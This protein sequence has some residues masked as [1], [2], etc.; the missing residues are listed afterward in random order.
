MSD[1]QRGMKV[2]FT[3]DWMRYKKGDEV[4]VSEAPGSNKVLTVVPHMGSGD[5]T[6]VPVNFVEKV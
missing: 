6:F 4:F 5:F 2:R 1:L 3:Q